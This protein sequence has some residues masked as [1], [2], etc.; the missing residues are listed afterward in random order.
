VGLGHLV[1]SFLHTGD[2]RS[3]CLQLQARASD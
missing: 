2:V 3:A 1:F